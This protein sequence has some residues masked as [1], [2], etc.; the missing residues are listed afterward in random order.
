MPRSARPPVAM[1]LAATVVAAGL[2]ALPAA[3]Y[4]AEDALPADFSSSFE[5]GDTQPTW[6]DTVDTD[7]AGKPRAF[8]VN[9]ANGTAIP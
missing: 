3:A 6:T 5:A 7:A 9:G 8:G 4:A 2:V 1:M